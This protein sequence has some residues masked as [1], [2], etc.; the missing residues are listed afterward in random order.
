AG[1]PRVQT[2]GHDFREW[3]GALGWIMENIFHLAPLMDGHLTAQ[4]RV[5]NTALSWL[6]QV[7]IQVQKAGR[8]SEELSA[9]DI[10]DLCD[11]TDIVLPGLKDSANDD[12]AL[13]HAGILLGRCFKDAN[14]LEIDGKKINRLEIDGF[15]VQRTISEE[16]DEFS[17]KRE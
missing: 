7:C 8:L 3:A 16:T 11:G 5:S 1:C 17:R 2:P 10:R 14:P 4:L 13:K 9:S 6:R 12:A 15:E